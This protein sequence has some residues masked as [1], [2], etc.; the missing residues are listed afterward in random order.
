MVIERP[1]LLSP[2]R[3]NQAGGDFGLRNLPPAGTI[4][5]AV[6][7]LATSAANDSRRTTGGS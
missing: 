3:T 1:P 7:L 6:A 5:H 4:T 2:P